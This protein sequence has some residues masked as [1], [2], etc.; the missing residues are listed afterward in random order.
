MTFL[1]TLNNQLGLVA[2]P[3]LLCSFLTVIILVERTLQMVLFSRGIRLNVRT[4][5]A[6]PM[7]QEQ[8]SIMALKSMLDNKQPLLYKGLN[9]IISHH[10]FP[11]SLREDAALIWLQERRYQFRSGFKALNLIAMISPL[12]GLLGTVLGL[13]AMFKS[14]ALS[15]GSIN[16][17]DL[18]DG[19][20][21]AMKTT[22]AGLIIALPAII[23]VQLLGMWSDRLLIKL[24][25]ALNYC[26]LWLEGFNL[27]QTHTES[28]TSPLAI[29]RS[30][31]LALQKA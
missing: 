9:M 21:L 20:G 19:L 4:I 2:L 10:H 6:T 16:P 13:M 7:D 17:S 29:N 8:Q 31:N 15:T 28:V 12:L 26:N 25:H 23:G 27:E 24:E 5:L 22:S 14:L 11:K 30:P 3:L 18:A 1:N